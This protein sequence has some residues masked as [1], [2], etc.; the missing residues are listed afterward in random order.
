MASD[1]H[2]PALV[3]LDHT[4]IHDVCLPTSRMAG[5]P[6]CLCSLH[7]HMR[8]RTFL[9]NT[10][11][12]KQLSSTSVNNTQTQPE[13]RAIHKPCISLRCSSS[14]S[15]SP[16]S[17][18]PAGKSHSGPARTVTATALYHPLISSSERTPAKLAIDL[19]WQWRRPELVPPTRRARERLPMAHERRRYDRGVHHRNTTDAR[20]L[21]LH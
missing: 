4:H 15:S 10:R 12:T 8:V 3:K 20:Q 18:S 17:P 1:P 2:L 6:H 14:P 9:H 5:S 19:L 11:S 16:P 13:Q 7:M 21:P